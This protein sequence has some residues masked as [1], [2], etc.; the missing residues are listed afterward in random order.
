MSVNIV[1]AADMTF[2]LPGCTGVSAG[3]TLAVYAH[4]AA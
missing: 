2:V 3:A 1:I 4:V